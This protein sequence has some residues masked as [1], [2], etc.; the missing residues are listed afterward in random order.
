[1]IL[2]WNFKSISWNFVGRL[3]NNRIYVKYWNFVVGRT[4]V[5]TKLHLK[6]GQ[7]SYTCEWDS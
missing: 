3:Q 5:S 6:S 1:M 2:K 4:R 7:V